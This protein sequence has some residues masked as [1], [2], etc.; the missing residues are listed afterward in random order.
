LSRASPAYPQLMAD[1]RPKRVRNKPVLFAEVP[2]DL[3]DWLDSL[4]PPG[5]KPNRSFHTRQALRLYREGGPEKIAAT[6]AA[7]DERIAAASHEEIDDDAR[8]LLAAFHQLDR[9]NEAATD[10]ALRIVRLAADP[11]LV[12]SIRS[13]AGVLEGLAGLGAERGSARSGAGPLDRARRRGGGKGT[14]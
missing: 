4:A 13:F 14:G 2:K 11:R 5:E 6:L 12:E 1:G 3:L 10:G 8:D 9:T 7:L